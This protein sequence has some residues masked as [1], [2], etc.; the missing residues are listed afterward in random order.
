MGQLTY[1]L[2]S[3]HL[4]ASVLHE[5]SGE[6]EGRGCLMQHDGQEDDHL[7][8]RVVRR[9]GR[10]HGDPVGSGVHHQT[11]ESSAC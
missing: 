4:H 7:D 10:A 1:L 2:Y 11:C 6:T 8:I 5:E 3:M 9:A